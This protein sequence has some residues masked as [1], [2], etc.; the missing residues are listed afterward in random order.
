MSQLTT[1]SL[2]TT[3][4]CR[5]CGSLLEEKFAD[6]GVSPL[7]NSYI[8]PGRASLMEPFYP[9]LAYVCGSCFLV[10][11][12]EFESPAAVFSSEYAYF[13]SYSTTWLEHAREYAQAMTKRF[14][15]TAE[16]LIIEAASNDGYLL[17]YFHQAGIPVLG[18]E[19]AGSVAAAA[20]EKGIPTREVFFSKETAAQ[21]VS[22]GLSADL[23]AGNNV[24][25]HVPDLHSFTEGIRIVLKPRGV[26]TLEFP[27]LLQMIAQNQ[28]DTI[29]HEHFSYFSLLT[30]ERVFA[31]H[32]L[33]IF[34]VDEMET[35][36]GSIRIYGKHVEDESHP[37]SPK[38]AALRQCEMAAGLHRIETYR[39]FASRVCDVKCALLD[40]LITCRREGKLVAGYG[41]P[42][43]G[44]TLLNYCGIGP[45]LLPF[46]VDRSPHKQGRL[47]PGSR[48]PIYAPEKIDATRPDYVLILPWNLKDEIAPQLEGIRAWG[49]RF[50][51]P[52]PSVQV[53]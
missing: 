36:G 48:I 28:F 27:H 40:F 33:T 46:T 1:P 3:P 23:L 17:Q 38:V 37:V 42:A 35:H 6:L 9:L 49:G 18:I 24:Y 11:L 31:E 52:I 26:V 15:L 12:Q 22:E 25:A 7:S 14:S 43:K 16:S 51:A 10:Q 47:L 45:E 20:I 50:V 8:Q 30:V 5:L 19:P 32:G 29:Y 34:D 2:D 21:L 53:F 44:N 39:G 13:S 4:R 41:A